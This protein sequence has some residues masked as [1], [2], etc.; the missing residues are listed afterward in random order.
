M[1]RTLLRFFIP[2][3]FIS[4]FLSGCVVQRSPVTGNKRA[5]GYT[6]EQEL[7]IG[8]EADQQIQD[9]YGVYDN[10]ELRQYVDNIGQ[11]MLKVSHMR[12]EDTPQKYKDTEFTFRVLDSPVI[13]AFALPGGYVYVTRGLL[14]H[15]DN[16]A[17]LAVV[18]GHEIGH[19]AARHASQRAF[20]QQ[21]GQLALIGGAVVGDQFLGIPGGSILNLGSQAAQFL[22]LSYGR[23]DER[24]SDK[25]GVEYSAMQNYEASEGAAFFTTLERM[26]K[27][28]GQNIP[29]WQSTHPDPE[30]RSQRIPKLA[31]EWAEKGYDLRIK[32]KDQY[33]GQIDNIIFGNNPREGF[34]RNGR[35]Y[36]PELAFDFPYPEQWTVINQRSLVAVINE[37]QDA[38]AI[39]RLDSKSETPEASVREFLSQEGITPGE[40][41]ATS[42]NNLEG[43]EATAT[44]QTE[45][46]QEL[47]FYIYSVS[48]N[49][50][51][52]RFITYSTLD[53]FPTY[54]SYFEEITHGFK[55]LRDEQILN[56]QPVRLHV[57]KS[58]T[59]GSF[60]SFLPSSYEGMPIELTDNDL[61]ILN[62]VQLGDTIQEGEWVKLPHK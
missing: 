11:E 23:D 26:S 13:N 34:T 62:Q 19:V 2:V 32:D 25:L 18:L 38:I 58:A 4:F 6:W 45:D 9:Q 47:K 61:A 42:Y 44:G 31:Q 33:M 51:I 14:A 49:G 5:Y 50:T 21:V 3:L 57:S 36:H 7:Q 60:Q 41:S 12:R 28:S 55:E 40:G 24:E 56:I 17:Q 53:Q 59:S 43:Y 35:F 10:E 54:R 52:Y 20:E 46:G 37:D 16:E 1:K 27:Q 8:K 15:L 48:Y 22:F 39:M 29:D 30:E